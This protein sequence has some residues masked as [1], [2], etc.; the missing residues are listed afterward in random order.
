M[1][2]MIER[3]PDPE[4]V[5]T[6]DD[7]QVRMLR[8]AWAMLLVVG[9]LAALAAPVVSA[10]NG[11][12]PWPTLLG[13]VA[14]L[15]LARLMFQ[16]AIRSA[17][18]RAAEKTGEPELGEG[19]SLARQLMD[20]LEREGPTH[21]ARLVAVAKQPL[22]NIERSLKALERYDAVEEAPDGRWTLGPKAPR[23][24]S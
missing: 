12:S 1:A 15:G 22:D 16:T 13:V 4:H 9:I 6:T 17:E 11:G 3:D 14:T 24:F 21:P 23:S 10:V 18:R 8:L 20:I 2:A 19:P 7:I 5:D